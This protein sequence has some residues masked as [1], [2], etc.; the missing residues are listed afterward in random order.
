MAIPLPWSNP[1]S[2]S[3]GLRDRGV[4]RHLS[5]A[6]PSKH[7]RQRSDAP[8]Y[9][10]HRSVCVPSQPR[11]RFPSSHL[12]PFSLSEHSTV[13]CRLSTIPMPTPID[14]RKK[15]ASVKIHVSTGAGVDITWSDGHASHYDFSLP[16]RRMP[17]RHLQRR[18]RKKARPSPPQA[19]PPPPPYPCSNPNP[20]RKSANAVGNYAIQFTFTDGHATGIYSYD[21]LRTICPCPDCAQTFRDP[22]AS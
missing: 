9:A 18:A 5:T 11:A 21:H 15:P 22:T 16:S 1:A 20:P 4:R 17:L 19:Q 13:N 7:L 12:P 10:E 14:Q 2:C 3:R 8:A 6:K